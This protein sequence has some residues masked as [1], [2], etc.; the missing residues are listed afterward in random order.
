MNLHTVFQ[1]DCSNWHSHKE[2]PFKTPHPCQPLLF[3]GFLMTAVWTDMRFSLWF[4]YMS[5]MLSIFLCTSCPSV[6]VFLGK[7]VN[8]SP[9][10]FLLYFCPWHTS[11]SNILHILLICC[12]FPLAKGKLCWVSKFCLICLL[13][14]LWYLEQCHE[15]REHSK[16]IYWMTGFLSALYT[17]SI[18]GKNGYKIGGGEIQLKKILTNK[19]YNYSFHLLCL[20]IIYS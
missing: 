15:H 14:F 20:S 1:R 9:L 5:L 18:K 17:I 12:Q 6:Y 2:F 8:W 4:W 10:S 11:R 16:H 13:L 19:G 3:L 7:N